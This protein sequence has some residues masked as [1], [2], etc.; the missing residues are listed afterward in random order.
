QRA[1]SRRYEVVPTAAL[2][3]AYQ[4][5][6]LTATA[7]MR[8]VF[9]GGADGYIKRWDFA[10]T[11]NGRQMMTQGQRH[12]HVDS[13]S[14]AGVMA[15]Y[16]EH[17]DN[18]VLSPVFSM[19]VQAQALWLVSGMQSGRI[20]LWS[21]RHDEGRKLHV[22]SKHRQPVS[23]LRISPDERGLVSGAWDRAVLYWDLDSGR[24]ARSFAGHAS[25]ISSIAFQPTWDAAKYN[26]LKNS[27]ADDSQ[28]PAENEGF[29]FK[30]PSPV[31]M[32]ASI[33]GQCL[34]WDVRMRAA[35]PHR[36][37]PPPRTPPWAA[38]ACWS[39][40][41]KRIFVGRRNNTVDEYEFNQGNQPVRSLR[42]PPNSGPVTALA[43]LPNN[44]SLICCST[45]NVRMWDLDEQKG[46][47]F[48]VIPGHHG[49]TVSCALVDEAARFMVTAC[50]NR[51]W[52]GVSNN[53]CLCYEIE[54]V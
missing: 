1:Q 49:S 52:D 26:A 29:D 32:T 2:L 17:S 12:A 43:A 8:W 50:G 21:V 31:L 24:L 15:G 46:V 39:P 13:V 45:D 14:K 44:R 23:V 33:D 16:W 53:V 51:G 54:S 41:G 47:R 35:L 22:L 9:S 30:T 11:M 28:A 3:N 18:D 6:T 37:D 36:F 20:A 4:I 48:M 5:H 40:D 27:P 10:A 34:L 7:D 19:D 25:Q 42:L 38:S